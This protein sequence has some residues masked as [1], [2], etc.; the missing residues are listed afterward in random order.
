MI[1]LIIN[2]EILVVGKMTIYI[3]IHVYIRVLLLALPFEKSHS[4]NVKRMDKSYRV[5][6]GN[7]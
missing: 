6:E 3:I 2:F 4:L 1:K 5:Y 7:Y